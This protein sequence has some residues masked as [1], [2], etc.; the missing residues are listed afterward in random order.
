MQ[1]YEYLCK[2]T[3]SILDL[4]DRLDRRTEGG[5]FKIDRHMNRSDELETSL[6]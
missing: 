6:L 4:V 3:A 1:G 5:E 2:R